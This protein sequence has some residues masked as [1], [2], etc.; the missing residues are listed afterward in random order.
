[1]SESKL[2][3]VKL[4]RACLYEYGGRVYHRGAEFDMPEAE[5]ERDAFALERATS[6]LE[7]KKAPAK[8]APKKAAPVKGEGEGE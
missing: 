4:T 2:I 1:M 5:F 6:E 7:P 8:K 3:R